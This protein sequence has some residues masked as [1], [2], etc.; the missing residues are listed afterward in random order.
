M[1]DE[2]SANESIDAA[3][4]MIEATGNVVGL[5]DGLKTG[6]EE[7]GWG[8]SAASH[9]ATTIGNTMMLGGIANNQAKR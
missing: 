6:L 1:T 8:P 5:L 2:Q 3:L 9:A 4:A 7:R